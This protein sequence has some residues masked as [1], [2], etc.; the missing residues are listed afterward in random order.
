ME[1]FELKKQ[2]IWIES[3]FFF[4][5]FL[6][7]KR[8]EVLVWIFSIQY[9]LNHHNSNI[10]KDPDIRLR[11]FRDLRRRFLRKAFREHN[12]S[13]LRR[14]KVGWRVGELGS[15]IQ[16]NH[17]LIWSDCAWSWPQVWLAYYLQENHNIFDNKLQ[18]FFLAW[19]RIC[20]RFVEFCYYILQMPI[21]IAWYLD[22]STIFEIAW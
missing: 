6:P 9:K 14:D 22:S 20:F 10:T 4:F 17:E 2:N 18:L 7:S 13:I 3:N 21:S 8:I 19:F 11:F 5:V 12:C 16:K 1:K 15:E